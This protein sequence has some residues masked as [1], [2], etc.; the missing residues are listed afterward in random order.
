MITRQNLLLHFLILLLSIVL[1][2]IT[3]YFYFDWFQHK[4]Y[5]GTISKVVKT[6]TDMIKG[7]EKIEGIA[8]LADQNIKSFEAVFKPLFCYVPIVVTPKK[9]PDQII[10]TNIPNEKEWT[11]RGRCKRY[12][13]KFDNPDWEK[14]TVV[15]VGSYD[16]K[17]GKYRI[18][19]W[20]PTYWK[21]FRNHADWFKS[22]HDTYTVTFIVHAI[23]FYL[24][25]WVFAWR[26]YS[27]HLAQDIKPLLEKL[28]SEAGRE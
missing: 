22:W 11:T 27:K 25:L 19:E 10:F 2:F 24:L 16:I 17:I 23:F 1:S 18:P 4:R 13:Y 26:Y 9:Q 20:S 7:I 28:N 5:F 6:Q 8:S 14:S 15:S 12:L 3:T 21:W